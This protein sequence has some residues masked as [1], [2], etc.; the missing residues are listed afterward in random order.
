MLKNSVFYFTLIHLIGVY[1]VNQNLMSQQAAVVLVTFNIA[2]WW[3]SNRIPMGISSLLPVALFPIYGIMSGK[4]TASYYMNS[5]IMIFIGGFLV[6]NAMQK[7]DLHKRIAL[8]ILSRSHGSV[9]R[10][11]WSFMG[12]SAFLSMWISNTA[13]TVMMVSIALALIINIEETIED[14]AKS[15]AISVA[16]LLGIAYAANVGGMSTIV[17]TATNLVFVHVYHEASGVDFSF[18]NWLLIGFPVSLTLVA[19]IGLW[20]DFVFLRKL[21]TKNIDTKHINKELQALGKMKKEEKLVAAVF[22]AMTFLWMFRKS[23]SL[24]MVKII[25]WSQLFN[26]PKFLDDGSVAVF[27]AIVLFLLPASTKRSGLLEAEDI[28]TIPWETILL[29]G[30][31]FAIAGSFQS[32][33]LTDDI[34]KQ[35]AGL[36]DFNYVT[37]IGLLA[38]IMSFVTE[39]TSNM[40]STELVL[41]ILIPLAKSMNLDPSFLMLPVTLAASCAF[42]LPAATAPNS[43]IVATGKIDIWTMVK[44]GFIL[45]VFA[46]MTICLFTYFLIPLV[47]GA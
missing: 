26:H 15:S 29:F 7:W 44:T 36:S 11:L 5:I 43:I 6:A 22:V 14:S 10:V 21:E 17:G 28:K 13:T 42:M 3:I 39:L 8:T 12:I 46:V 9:T 40:S 33:G 27:C 31:G 34:A 16:L 1:L 35:L 41:P 47:L 30:G 4:Q 20:L 32:S 2:F 45:N 24:G 38:T 18:A 19:F 37:T 23:F 25:G